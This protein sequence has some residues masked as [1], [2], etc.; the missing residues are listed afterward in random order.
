MNTIAGCAARGAAAVC[1][2]E[3]CCDPQPTTPLTTNNNAKPAIALAGRLI[4]SIIDPSR[5]WKA[6]GTTDCRRNR[7]KSEMLNSNRPALVRASRFSYDSQVTLLNWLAAAVLFLQ[8][9]IPLYWFLLHPMVRFWRGRSQ[10]AP[11]MTPKLTLTLALLLSWTPVCALIVVF[12]RQLFRPARPPAAL[13]ALG[14]ALIALEIWLFG[15][16][17][18]DLGASRLVGKTEIEGGGSIARHGIYARVRHPRYA[19]SFLAI[20]GACLLGARAVLWLGFALWTALMLVVISLEEREMHSRFGAQ[21]EEYAREVP[22]FLPSWRN[23][24]Q[25][26]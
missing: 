10:L 17:T 16:L 6:L 7:T 19:A 22:R 15:K 26:G 23:P 2:C 9:P 1:A 20:L 8:L 24:P 12:R 18:R 21:Y 4:I 13:I 3:L 25:R 11:K 14:I 5:A